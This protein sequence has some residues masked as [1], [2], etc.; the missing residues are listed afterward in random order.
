V[1]LTV[2]FSRAGSPFT[3]VADITQKMNLGVV[4]PKAGRRIKSGRAD[5]DSCHGIEKPATPLRARYL[6][7]RSTV[8]L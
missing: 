1:V 6:P 8:R 5:C 2:G 7:S 4:F 3:G